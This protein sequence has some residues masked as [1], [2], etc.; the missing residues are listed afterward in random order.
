MS[1]YDPIELLFGGM[2]KLGPGDDSSTLHALKLLPKK[3]FN[4]VVDAGC[5]SGRQTLVLAKALGTVVHAIDV[6]APFLN[7]LNQRARENGIESLVQTHCMDMQDIST[8]FHDIDLLWSEGSA[9]NIGFSNAL[10]SWAPA[11]RHGGFLV[12]SELCW[13]TEKIPDEVKAFFKTE[14]PDMHSV[15]YNMEVCERAG[16]KLLGTYSIPD[17]SWV[18]GYYDVLEPRARALSAHVDASVRAFAEEMLREIEVFGL[19]QDSYGYVFYI[20]QRN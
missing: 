11:I 17:E 10:E 9:Y 6:Y 3:N 14:Y 19:S 18:E 2:E 15:Q 20:L 8:T 16:Y 4:Q 5:G 7:E 12:V 13:L 1:N